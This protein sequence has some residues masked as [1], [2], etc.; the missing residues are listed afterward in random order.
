MN[1]TEKTEDEGDEEE[2]EKREEGYV[3]IGFDDLEC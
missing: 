1:G 2:G 3:K